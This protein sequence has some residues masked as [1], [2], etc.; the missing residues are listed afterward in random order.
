MAS[1]AISTAMYKDLKN[2]T[3]WR[4]SNAGS[5]VL[6]ADAMATPKTL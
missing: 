1:F 3:T 2:N 5:S 4:D 6:L